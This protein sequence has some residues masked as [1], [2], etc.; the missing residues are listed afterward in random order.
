MFFS[1]ADSASS[2]LSSQTFLS[3]VTRHFSCATCFCRWQLVVSE[4]IRQVSR[5]LID[6]AEI[7][8]SDNISLPL[9]SS[10]LMSQKS[11]EVRENASRQDP[12]HFSTSIKKE[13]ALSWR[14]VSQDNSQEDEGRR[15][16][17]ARSARNLLRDGRTLCPINALIVTHVCYKFP[18]VPFG[19][20]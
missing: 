20:E 12:L 15:A 14:N 2:F 13:I 7:I 11:T 17:G 5:S 10:S 16:K 6:Y 3:I 4:F 8:F 1:H 19:W 9:L 18:F